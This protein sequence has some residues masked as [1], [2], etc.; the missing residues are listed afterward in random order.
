M[1]RVVGSSGCGVPLHVAPT[2][3]IHLRDFS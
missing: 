2:G 1:I 3:L